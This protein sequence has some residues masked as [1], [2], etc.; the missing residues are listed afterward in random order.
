[1]YCKLERIQE[2]VIAAYFRELS[3]NLPGR[4]MENLRYPCLGLTVPQQKL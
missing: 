3:W 2:E 1:M 4:N